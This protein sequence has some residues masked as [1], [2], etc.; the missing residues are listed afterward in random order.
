MEGGHVILAL[1]RAMARTGLESG[2][3]AD[4][5]RCWVEISSKCNV[6]F[7]NLLIISSLYVQHCRFGKY[8]EFSL[9]KGLSERTRGQ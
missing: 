4:N 8:V 9:Q 7:E 5:S 6:L 3:R 1:W 2:R